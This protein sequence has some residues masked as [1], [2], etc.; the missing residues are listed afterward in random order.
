MFC[1]SVMPR[2]FVESGNLFLRCY[3]QNLARSKRNLLVLRFLIMLIKD[4]EVCFL[5]SKAS[6]LAWKQVTRICYIHLPEP[7]FLCARGLQNAEITRPFLLQIGCLCMNIS[8][9]Y[10]P[11]SQEMVAIFHPD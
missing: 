7:S 10:R 8:R 11:E 2:N 9:V 5:A 4:M 3:R 6:I 1:I